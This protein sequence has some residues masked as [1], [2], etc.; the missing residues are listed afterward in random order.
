M[1][2]HAA[3]GS[4]LSYRR[5]GLR[6]TVDQEIGA[7][8]RAVAP[9]PVI[10]PIIAGVASLI[11]AFN[12]GEGCGGTCKAATAIVNAIEPLLKQNLAA[13]QQTVMQ[14]GC[15]TPAE[16]QQCLANFTQL[17]QAVVVGCSQIPA[18]GGTQCLA[19]REPGGKTDWFSYYQAPLQQMPV[20][21]AAPATSSA[22]ATGPVA[23]ATLT[24]AITDVPTEVWLIAAAI[25]AVLLI[26]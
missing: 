6:A 15:L 10:G 13:A 16:Q 3:M 19:D 1:I 23:A 20:C 11:Q 17:W 4:S 5:R 8:G 24:T 7:A 25:G 2:H 9:V 12:I 22:I 21:A 18:P 26:R 14:N